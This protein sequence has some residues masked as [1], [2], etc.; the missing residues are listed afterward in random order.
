[1]LLTNYQAEY[2][3]SSGGTINVVIKNGTRDFHGGGFYFKRHEQF[4]AN[5]FF[6]NLRNQPKPRYRFNYWGGNIGGPVIIPGTKFNK[7]RDKLF[8]FWSQECLPRV[9]PT[10]QGTITYPTALE[11]AGDFSQSL[12]TNGRLIVDPR[13]QRQDCHFPAIRSLTSRIDA[14]GQKLL[15]I[16][17]LP[18]FNPATVGYNYNNVFQ[19]TVD[20][21]RRE[22]ILRMD[23][24]ISPK[25]TFYAR[26]IQNYEAFKGDFNFVLASNVWPQ[27]P[28]K[29]AIES[30]GLVSTLDPHFSARRSP[31]NSRSASTAHCRR[32]IPLNQE[33]IDRNDRV[34]LG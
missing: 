7:N 29:Y 15:S 30:R 5:E 11:R 34:K 27:F 25:T 24:N 2:G 28:I 3:R 31:T 17:P 20:Q 23:W 33:G 16:F 6:N 4:N 12:D 10:R 9:Y 32:S 22:E 8:F 19:S 14:N 1:M 18:N 21:P 13:S 26:G